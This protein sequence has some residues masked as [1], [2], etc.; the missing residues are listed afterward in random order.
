MLLGYRVNAAPFT[1][2]VVLLLFN[3]VIPLRI[4]GVSRL[5]CKGGEGGGGGGKRWEEEKP[6]PLF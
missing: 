6:V 1:K 5:H 2:L 4:T 3:C